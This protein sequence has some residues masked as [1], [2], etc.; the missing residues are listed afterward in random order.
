MIKR[1]FF[2]ALLI[3][4]LLL[5]LWLWIAWFFTPNRKLVIAIVDKTVLN[6]TGQEHIS[7]TWVLHNNRFLKTSSQ[8]YKNNHDYFKVDM[9]LGIKP[10]K[11]PEHTA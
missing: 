2:F 5:P 7:L 9:L 11:R 6:Q 3:I 4:L 10:C 1:R 8:P